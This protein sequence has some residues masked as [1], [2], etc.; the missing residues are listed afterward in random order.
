M[1]DWTQIASQLKDK[2][3]SKEPEIKIRDV[4]AWFSLSSTSSAYY[5]LLKLEEYG[6]VKHV[7]DRWFL[8]W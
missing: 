6:A 3:A 5:Y 4:M 1:N 2:M 8:A 7:K